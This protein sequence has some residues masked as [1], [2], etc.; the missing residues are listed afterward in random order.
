MLI[1]EPD[2][3]AGAGKT[4]IFYVMHTGNLGHERA[5][6]GQIV[7]SLANNAEKVKGGPVYWN[8]SGGA[9]ALDVCVEQRLRFPKSVSLQTA[10]LST[11][12]SCRRATIA[13]PCGASG[14]VLTLSANGS[15]AGSGI[16]WSSMPLADDGDH[17]VHQ[18]VLRAF[19]ADDLTKELWNSRLNAA[20]RR[21]RKLAK[22]QPATVANGRCTW[23]RFP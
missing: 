12:E 15:T 4:S 20:P 16:I 17:G 1:P 9:G 7:Q 21:Q 13:S 2:L 8:R 11:R 23:L 3:I 22:V 19:N 5:G 14:G 6:N 18:G 10:L